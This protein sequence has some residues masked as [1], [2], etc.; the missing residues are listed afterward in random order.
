MIVGSVGIY[1]MTKSHLDQDPHFHHYR[2]EFAERRYIAR[3]QRA[4]VALCRGVMFDVPK[5]QSRDFRYALDIDGFAVA[6]EN[7]E[8]ISGIK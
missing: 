8:S 4:A 6:Q 2:S 7:I 1:N 3:K 5:C